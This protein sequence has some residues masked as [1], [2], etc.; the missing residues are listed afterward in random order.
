MPTMT[1]REYLAVSI[2]LIAVLGFFYFSGLFSFNTNTDNLSIESLL[3]ESL[4]SGEDIEV[5]VQREVF[6]GRVLITD[7]QKGSGA[8]IAPG[9]I[10]T[11]HYIGELTN[12]E[13]FD[14]SYDN[15]RPIQFISGIGMLIPG[16]DGGLQGM[17][18]GGKRTLIITPE[19]AFGEEGAGSIP[20]DSTVVFYVEILEIQTE[21]EFLDSQ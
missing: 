14:S 10:V 17:S 13:V 2:A 15:D 5:G 18:V 1:F 12:G 9:S 3:E 21:E 11:M 16:L 6:D 19:L 8:V 20:P 7:T 4:M